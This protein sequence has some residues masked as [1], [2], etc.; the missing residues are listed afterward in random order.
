VSGV[1]HRVVAAGEA[2]LRFDRWC[3]RH[4]P[5]LGHVQLQKLLRTGQ[6]RLDGKR[7]EAGTRVQPGQTIRVPPMELAAAAERRGP[8]EAD[9]RFIKSLVIHDDDRLVVLAKPEGLAVQ[10]GTKTTRH[11]DGMLDALARKG[12]RP[13]LV[14]RLDRDT[15]GLLVLARDATVAR[16]LMHAFQQH[17]VRKLYWAIVQGSPDRNEGLIDLGLGK[18]G[19]KGFERMTPDALDARRAQ[20]DFRVIARTG[21]VAAWV[22]LMPRT[23]RTH[24]LRA[25][26]AAIG[27]PIVGDRKYAPVAGREQPATAP[28]GLMLHAREIE[29]PRGKGPPLRLTAEAPRHFR[30]GLAWLGLDAEAL[31]FSRL[32]DWPEEG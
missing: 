6:F 1:T 27:T 31:K 13:K 17:R 28:E 15:S 12:E 20:T 16:E 29:L 25:H 11:V 8:S 9:A 3:K 14:H 30:E 5:T 7:V 19:A 2:D 10:G 21:K 22:G 23:G 24:Q 18:A 26:M 32:Q 4:F